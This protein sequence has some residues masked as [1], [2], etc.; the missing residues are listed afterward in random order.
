M[1]SDRTKEVVQA[2]MV[3]LDSQFPS[4]KEYIF[5]LKSDTQGHELEVL[6]GA[7][8]MLKE[9]RVQF[10]LLEMSVYLMPRPEKD[11]RKIMNILDEAG[12]VCLDLPWH[13]P[14]GAPCDDFSVSNNNRQW[15]Q[16]LY[17]HWKGGCLSD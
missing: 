10:I 13:T 11:G 7:Q 5:L 14:A 9:R 6:E 8:Q 3:T 1:G 17:E 4:A 2:R 16:S 15:V 12:F